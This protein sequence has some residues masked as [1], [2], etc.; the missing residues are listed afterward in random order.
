[1]Q[2]ANHLQILYKKK[3][4]LIDAL[5]QSSDSRLG[6]CRVLDSMVC[7]TC[8][9]T[10]ALF[11][12]THGSSELGRGRI[13]HRAHFLRPRFSSGGAFHNDYIR[14][15]SRSL[16]YTLIPYLPQPSQNILLHSLLS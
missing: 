5:F 7:R 16:S 10:A 3:E 8:P 9:T 2:H 15:A 12:S 13:F 4:G 14:L 11:S 1:M 6:C